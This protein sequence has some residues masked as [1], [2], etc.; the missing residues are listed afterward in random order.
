MNQKISLHEFMLRLEDFLKTNTPV[1][2]W[3][4]VLVKYKS[5]KPYLVCV[6]KQTQLTL[7]DGGKNNTEEENHE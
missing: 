4:E 5:S 1:S 3:G 7:L 2:F 6:T